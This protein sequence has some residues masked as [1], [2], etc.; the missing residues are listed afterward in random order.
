[1]H[2][3]IIIYTLSPETLFTYNIKGGII[4]KLEIKTRINVDCEFTNIYK[5]KQTIFTLM[6]NFK[7]K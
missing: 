4:Q 2:Y 1:M 6:Q 7:N 3:C 5:F